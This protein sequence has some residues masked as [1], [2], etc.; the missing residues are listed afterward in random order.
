MQTKMGRASQIGLRNYYILHGSFQRFGFF[1]RGGIFLDCPE[2]S[3]LCGEQSISSS[4]D[5][6]RS[7]SE[8][9]VKYPEG[10]SYKAFPCN[11]VEMKSYETTAVSAG[12]VDCT[13][14]LLEDAGDKRRLSGEENTEPTSISTTRKRPRIQEYT[15][16][17]NPRF[18]HVTMNQ[19]SPLSERRGKKNA[20]KICTD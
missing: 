18:Q 11:A 1:T 4:L 12:K 10:R 6:T 7:N 16:K 3:E 9:L 17:R 14:S 8:S 13:L 2:P 15:E 19:I 20:E 5:S